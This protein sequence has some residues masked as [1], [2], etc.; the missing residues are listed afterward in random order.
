MLRESAALLEAHCEEAERLRKEIQALHDNSTTTDFGVPSNAFFAAEMLGGDADL[1]A[2]EERLFALEAEVEASLRELP[3]L[4]G[5][6]QHLLQQAISSIPDKPGTAT[7][8]SRNQ[9]TTAPDSPPPMKLPLLTDRRAGPSLARE[10]TAVGSPQQYHLSASLAHPGRGPQNMGQLQLPK[11][12]NRSG[13]QAG[14]GQWEGKTAD[15]ISLDAATAHDS[16]SSSA[17]KAEV[18]RKGIRTQ[19]ANST[20]STALGGGSNED[21]TERCFTGEEASRA[22]VYGKTTACMDVTDCTT[23]GAQ[24]LTRGAPSDKPAGRLSDTSYPESEPDQEEIRTA[25]SD[26]QLAEDDSRRLVLQQKP[27]PSA[28]P[29]FSMPRRGPRL[30][31]RLHIESSKAVLLR[32]RRYQI[33]E[34]QVPSQ[35]IKCKPVGGGGSPSGQL[36]RND[37][38]SL[39]GLSSREA[40]ADSSHCPSTAAADVGLTAASEQRTL[41]EPPG[42][43]DC[44]VTRVGTGW[45]A[46]GHKAPPTFNPRAELHEPSGL[47]WGNVSADSTAAENA[48][49]GAEELQAG[50]IAILSR[51]KQLDSVTVKDTLQGPAFDQCNKGTLIKVHSC[52]LSANKHHPAPR[53]ACGLPRPQGFVNPCGSHEGEPDSTTSCGWSSN[54]AQNLQRG[55][56]L[57]ND[58]HSILSAVEGE[59]ILLKQ[60]EPGL[61]VDS[62]SSAKTA[63][64]PLAGTHAL[65]LSGSFAVCR[66][67]ADDDCHSSTGSGDNSPLLLSL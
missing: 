44:L 36:A 4:E 47:Y 37:A 2:V 62:S 39:R 48:T 32:Q 28:L 40:P 3:A 34:C 7:Q 52:S 51:Q 58:G 27:I 24:R 16:A 30:G 38:S 42:E 53:I 21:T 23:V 11:P 59:P 12:L 10:G 46:G 6:Q 49:A 43:A 1:L 17:E 9:C 20:L 8:L 35:V 13:V 50:P 65:T 61:A 67:S 5:V 25:L 18:L 19:R 22:V 41:G 31:S 63:A 57:Q 56:A 60:P 54:Y 64:P 26:S 29:H 45:E 14:E 55:H 15:A 33:R 66:S